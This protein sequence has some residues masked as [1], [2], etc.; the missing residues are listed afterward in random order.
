MLRAAR[1]GDE[2]ARDEL[3]RRH[4]PTVQRMV[5]TWLG[6]DVRT[7]RPWV[8]SLFSTG[9]VVQEVFLGVLRDLGD[10]RADD[11]DSF[12][13]LLATLVKNRVVDALRRHQAVCR[14]ARRSRHEDP[15]ITRPGPEAENPAHRA[16]IRDAIESYRAEL[17]RLSRR[18]QALM[19]RRFERGEAWAVIAR[20]LAYPS[21]DAARKAFVSAK[22]RLLAR[23]ARSL[24]TPQRGNA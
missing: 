3:L 7:S 4:Y 14:D 20:E 23:L 11:E 5:H 12:V 1:Q 15:A 17:L 2:S 22:A 16:A 24:D 6:S 8:S 10:V 9:D 21:E 19:E 18:E 13:S